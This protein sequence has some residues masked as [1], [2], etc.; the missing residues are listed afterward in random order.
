MDA[1]SAWADQG[2]EHGCVVGAEQQTAGRGRRGHVWSS[3]PGAGLYFSF[4]AR[5]YSSLG[6]SLLTLAAGVGVQAGIRAATGFDAELKWPNDVMVGRRKLAGILAEGSG[7]GTS[8]QFVI[9]G[10]GINVR[11]A[12]YPPDVAARATSLAGELQREI[13]RGEVWFQTATALHKWLLDAGEQPADVVTNW[14]RRAPAAHG[15]RVEWN[16]GR[17][18]TAGVDRS[19]ALLVA[20][21]TGLERI[22]SGEVN[23]SS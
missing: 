22:I 7:I 13:D 12:S 2:A 14:L 10:V 17:G 19:G 1:A 4:I 18:V 20:T 6:L 8:R 5:P 21:P 23:W 9:I 15:T 3:P 16:G 11:P